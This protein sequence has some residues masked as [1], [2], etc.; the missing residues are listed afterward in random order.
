MSGFLTALAGGV[1]GFG[2]GLQEQAKR[3]REDFLADK[4]FGL[5][6][7]LTKEDRD[8]RV[9]EAE[10]QREFQSLERED[11]QAFVASESDKRIGADVSMFKA[12]AA[13]AANK[14]PTPQ[15]AIA[16]INADL[17]NGLISKDEAEA[18]ANK[19]LSASGQRIGF[20]EN[21][22][23]YVETGGAVGTT[24]GKAGKNKLDIAEID[25]RDSLAR[26]DRI[27]ANLA[28]PEVLESLTAAGALKRWGLEWQDYLSPDSLTPD[29]Q[30]YLV[31]VTQARAD[32]L[33]NVN[34]TIKAITGAAM[35][36]SEAKRIGATLPNVN[37]TPA[38]FMAKLETATKRTRM[39]V[40]RYNMWRG[41][42][43]GGRPEDI[44]TLS[45][46]EDRV[47]TRRS[48]LM[49]MVQANEMTADEASAAF[50]KEFGI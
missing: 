11:Q 18:S 48:E 46:I 2:A 23:M 28:N 37:D 13:V 25:A 15:T 8:F 49:R 14:P 41:Q 31:N 4:E 27:D 43:L 45:G 19:A 17:N 30:K 35:T 9:S 6:R 12:K 26:L 50:A 20:D 21:G 29:Q 34:Y 40:A 38:T 44:D 47:E 10:K 42:G 24:L 36:E 3:E 33:D 32:I 1:S 5:R 22:N 16:K 39:A 7:Q